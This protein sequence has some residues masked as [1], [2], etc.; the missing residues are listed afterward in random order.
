MAESEHKLYTLDDL[1][2]VQFEEPTILPDPIILPNAEEGEHQIK[3]DYTDYMG[4]ESRMFAFIPLIEINKGY[5]AN[6]SNITD[7]RL[8]FNSFM[9]SVYVK[10]NDPNNELKSK[11]YPTD[12]SLLSVYIAPMGEDDNYKAFRLDFIITSVTES[13]SYTGTVITESLSEFTIS[14]ELNIPEMFYNRNSYESGS[15]WE[16]LKSIALQTGLGF[17]S[18]VENTEDSQVWLNGYSSVRNFT[19]Y[20]A[21]HAYLDDSSFFVSFIDPYYNLNLI[22]ASRLFSQNPEN[23]KCWTYTT[24]FYEEENSTANANYDTVDEEEEDFMKW[25]G[26]RHKWWYELNNSKYLSGWTLYFDKYHE[27]NSNASSLYDGYT[28][29]VQS[30]DWCNREKIELPLSIDNFGTEGMFP[31][32]KG[33]MVNGEPS[34]LSKHMVSWTYMGETNEHMNPEYYYAEAN[35][36]MNLNDMAKFGMDVELPCVNPAITK[37]SRIKVIVFEKNDNAQAGLTENKNMTEDSEITLDNGKI[38]KLS[39]YPELQSDTTPRFDLTTDS[40]IEQAKQAGVYSE[41]ASAGADSEF[42]DAGE[43]LNESL[44]GW[45]VV[46]GFEIYLNDVNEDGGQMR[47]KQKIHL[48]RREYK[49]ALKKDYDKTTKEEN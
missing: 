29:Y 17:V 39:D 21:K 46:T 37:Y 1:K 12:G 7:F 6:S 9:P 49:P 30:W 13:S 32:N 45:Y 40:G 25:N 22:E 8:D 4:D 38:L 23:E 19:E 5:R 11:Y 20:I 44:S 43:T 34:E 41:M 2:A 33:H 26:R 14:G 47:L 35:N 24:M 18:N 31:L 42:N 10:L 28:K 16:A 15:S 48:A 36:N 3:K 27:K